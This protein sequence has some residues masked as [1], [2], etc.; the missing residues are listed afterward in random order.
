MAVASPDKQVGDY[1]IDTDP[2]QALGVGSYGKVFVGRHTKSGKDV[3]AKLIEWE[4]DLVTK[5]MDREAELMMKIPRHPNVLGIITY[6]KRDVWKGIKKK[7]LYTQGWLILELCTIGNLA[8]YAEDKALSV[9]QKVDLI[10]Q[11][12]RGLQHLHQQTPAII[13]HDIKLA[14]LLVAGSEEHPIVKVADF[15]ISKFFAHSGEFSL[16]KRTREGTEW[17]LAPELFRLE[18]DNRPKYNK[19]IDIFAMGVSGLTLEEAQPGDR[20]RTYTGN[21]CTTL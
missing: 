2:D 10:L 3:A 20:V 21:I 13:H 7:K 5:K 19:A 6:I 9:A 14:N 8:E 11:G 15:G 18:K 1:D 17:Y 4:K 16:T 12:C